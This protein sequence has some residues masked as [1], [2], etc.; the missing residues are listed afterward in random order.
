LR[1]AR[2]RAMNRFAAALPFTNFARFR[3]REDDCE[4]EVR[5]RRRVFLAR[6]FEELEP[7][8]LRRRR[9]PPGE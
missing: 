3:F 2:S 5:E 8:L 6:R 9:P 1:I 4:A 7:F